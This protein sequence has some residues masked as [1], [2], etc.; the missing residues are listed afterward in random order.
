MI[1]TATNRKVAD[2]EV[3]QKPVQVGFSPDGRFVYV[4]LNGENAVGKVDVS[5]RKLAGK[6]QVG[7]GPIQV[8]VTPDGKY[9]LAANQ[10]TKDKPSTT[11]SIV[12]TA[13]FTVLDTVPTGQGA[14]GVVIEPSSRYAYIT[15]LYGND[16]AV[17]DIAARK[18]VARTLTGAA[19]N[20]ISFLPL[21][22]APALSGQIELKL[23]AME[24]NMGH[25][26]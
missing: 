15:N 19:P 18:I 2:I 21:A 23:P 16:I 25:G 8:Y 22:P 20:G 1:D 11:V 10:G 5:T 14:H 4:S 26:G 9:L 3:G 24:Q 13:T 7:A 12:D 6:V 17:L